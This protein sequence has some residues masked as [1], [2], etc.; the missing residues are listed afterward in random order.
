M[1]K[2]TQS[3]KNIETLKCN[4][5]DQLLRAQAEFD[6]FRKRT[7][8]ERMSLI[9]FAN[10]QI[11]SDIL[12]VLDNFKRAA[13]HAPKTADT[14]ITNWIIG[15]D[16]IEKQLEDVL[17]QVGLEEV[18]V[19]IGD[20]F[21]H[22]VHEAISHDIHDAPEDTIIDIIEPGYTFNERLLRPVKVRVSSG[23]K[24]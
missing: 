12:P 9:K 23:N 3:K 20:M 4:M 2:Q 10:A 22:N 17:G 24:S 6:N 21:N 8:Q 1:K 7:E 16:A 11:V 19:H 18:P 5:K 13:H 14:S 15:I